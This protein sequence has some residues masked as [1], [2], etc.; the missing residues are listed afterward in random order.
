MAIYYKAYVYD[1]KLF[2]NDSLFYVE[3][4]TM[5]KL[6]EV[7]HRGKIHSVQLN[8]DNCARRIYLHV[9]DCQCWK[10]DIISY[11]INFI[12]FQGE[13]TQTMIPLS[14]NLRIISKN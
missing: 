6:G 1:V 13:V 5:Q 3:L 9:P 7:T 2:S 4:L 10:S 14:S 11:Y 12:Y 8:K